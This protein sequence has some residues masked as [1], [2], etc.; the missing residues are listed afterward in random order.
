MNGPDNPIGWCDYTWN[1]VTGCKHGCRFQA[2]CLS[3]RA[4]CY[5]A[6]IAHRFKGSK[7]WPNGFEP[8]FH[9]K[10]LAEPARVKKPSRIFVCSTGDLFGPWVDVA[11]LHAVLD[12]VRSCHWHTFQFLTKSPEMA[13][14]IPFPPNAWAGT[15]IT[16][17]PSEDTT[18]RL[19]LVR[20]FRAPAR[21]LSCEPLCGPVEVARAEPDWIIVGPATGPGGFQPEEQ[22]VRDIEA[23]ADEHRVPVFH[24]DALVCRQGDKRRMEFPRAHRSVGEAVYGGA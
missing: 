17:Q 15:S 10:R 19:D 3:P 4:T 24:K 11:W 8:T 7:A 22:W 14:L 1:P 21:F 20:K 9:D 6:A 12:V 18:R 13:A 2:E 23:Y 5:A 16:A